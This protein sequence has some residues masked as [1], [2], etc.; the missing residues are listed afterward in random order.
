MGKRKKLLDTAVD[1]WFDEYPVGYT[2][3]AAKFGIRPATLFNSI[4]RR[5]ARLPEPL[6]PKLIRFWEA[7]PQTFLGRFSMEINKLSDIPA[8]RPLTLAERKAIFKDR[9]DMKVRLICSESM[10]EV[11]V[12]SC[13]DEL[14]KKN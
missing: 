10:L 11:A 12:E 14:K 5:V 7:K 4:R 1:Y 8:D 6:R 3:V 2:E 9:Q 13:K